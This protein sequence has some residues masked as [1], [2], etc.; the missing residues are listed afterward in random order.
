MSFAGHNTDQMKSLKVKKVNVDTA[1]DARHVPALL[2]KAEVDYQ[3]IDVVN[4]PAFPYRPEV[5]F[6]IGYTNDAVLLH[7]KVTEKSVRAHYGKDDDPVY[8]DSCV[9]FFISPGGDQIYYN[10]ECNC[11]GTIL[12]GGGEPGNRDRA[13]AE[14]MNTIGRWA[15]LGTAPFDERIGQTEWEV[16]LVVPFTAFYKHRLSSLSGQD[17]RANFYKCGDDLTT[18]HFL[19]WS[20]IRVE[21]PNFHLPAFFGVLHFE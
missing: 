21:R 14:V 16:A 15:G 1:V 6:R 3:P 12:F 10:L 7:Y 19:S 9:E 8:K 4:W 18:P 5:S 11:I 13:D 20:P 17:I 2:D